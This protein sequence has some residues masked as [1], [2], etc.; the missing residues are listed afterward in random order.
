MD[1]TLGIDLGTNSIGMTLRNEDFFKWYGVYTFKKG[2]G[3]G[4]S[5]EFSLAAE[6]TKNRSSRRLYNARRYRKWATLE[7]LIKNDFCPLP[8]ED[9]EKWKH[10]EKGVGRKFPVHNEKFNQ[11][12]KL[13]FNFDGAPDYSSPYQLRR[14]LITERLD[15]TIQG[16]R[17]KIGRA[18]YH[19]AQRRGFKSSR[20]IG[21]NE[22]TAVYKGSKETGTIGRNEYEDLIE[23]NG[24]LGAA[25]AKLEDEGIRIR[26]RYTLRSDYY[27]EVEKILTFQEIFDE[28]MI[29]AILKA[30]FFQRPL[31]SQKG[32]IGKCTMEPNK[33]RCPISHPN[34]EEYRA[35]SFVNNIKYK[36]TEEDDF[37]PL[38][39]PLKE[40]LIKEKLFLK[41]N[42]VDFLQLRKFICKDERKNWILNYSKRMDKVSVSTCPVSTYLQAAF[43]ENWREIQIKSNRIRKDNGNKI[44]Y[45]IEDIWHILFSFEDEEYF[46]EF[47]IT[48]LELEENQISELLKLWK[49]FPVGYANL[50][51]KAINH[52]LPFL[53]KGIIYSEAVFLAKIPEMIGKQLFED[54]SEELILQFEKLIDTIKY[55]KSIINI[56]NSLI[57]TYKGQ[58]ID[59]R[60]ARK[61]FSY[62]L[63]EYDQKDVLRT[64]EDYYGKKTW[65]SLGETDKENLLND[66]AAEYQEFFKDTK[67]DYRKQPKLV[68]AFYNFLSENFSLNEKQ[69]KKL[70]HPSMID[71]YPSEEDQTLLKSP[72]TRA[73]KNPMAYKTLHKLR[74]VINHLIEKGLIDNETRIVLEVARELNDKN[75]RAAIEDYQRERERENLEYA[76]AIS[77]LINDPDFSG[78][79]NPNSPTDREKFRIWSEQTNVSEDDLKE[80]FRA[81]SSVKKYRLWKEQNAVCLYTGRF[82]SLTDLFNENVI[83]FEHT[84]P[85]S[86]SF[87]NSLANLTVCY[88]D[89]NRNVKKNQIPT[90]LPNY[91]ENSGGYQAIEPRLENWKKK[92][93]SLENQIET[94]VIKSKTA[95]DKETKDNAIR[96]RHYLKMHLDYWQNKLDRFTREDVPTGFRNS[97]LVDTQLISKYAY[98]YLKTVFNQ[99]DVIK[100]STTAEFRKIYGI[101]P[102]DAEKDRSNHYHH[103]IDAAV[104]TLLPSSAR[105]KDI[106][107]KKYRFEEKYKNKTYHEKPF[108]SFD[109]SMIEKIKKEILI[110]NMNDQDKVLAPVI[111]RVR[112]RGKI[113][114]LRDEDG[115]FVKDDNGKRIP[116]ITTGDAVRGQ[117][118]LDTFYGKIKIAAKDENGS[119]LR[120][121]SGDIVYLEENG[122]EVFKM[123]GRKPIEKVNFSSDNIIDK[124]LEDYLRK[125]LDSGVKQNELKDFQGNVVRHLRCEVK[126]GKGY[127]KPDNA[128]IVKEQTYKSK[129]EYKNFYYADSGDNYMF[130]LYENEYGRKIISI[131]VLEATKYTVDQNKDS[132]SE[133]FQTIEPISIGKGKHQELGKLKHIFMPGQKILFFFESKEE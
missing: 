48:S 70:Y 131:N 116:K 41:K 36:E 120:D 128:T 27:K 121:E 132:K 76:M 34:F 65:E 52:I 98:H 23:K 60:H 73:F 85:R 3:D 89:Y 109:Y 80:I 101:Q 45:N 106:L 110:N 68:E 64:L 93:E 6:R 12:I 86:L 54:N 25:F 55:Q 133:I 111:K 72:K 107:E 9:L 67:R 113:E 24:S 75:K 71:I 2:V 81:E 95:Q 58:E 42:N 30:I 49:N 94:Q 62:L 33:P 32:L 46:E 43:G 123:V 104:L 74:Q 69:L 7:V 57:A 115:Q 96:R 100:G 53:K 87:D 129:K 91:S 13:D 51:L 35:W 79:A 17:Y 102:S 108:E 59:D 18:L 22:K 88:A 26:N 90:Q 127:M 83:D 47:L 103:A 63:N 97:Q 21:A 29:H 39:L 66:V 130:G 77:E 126:S 50:S 44:I 5:G 37:Q 84:I 82:I 114:Y 38:P 78:N 19:I 10:Y 124:Q 105:R 40:N 112:S 20:K 15:L 122:K 16:N 11:W 125:Q 14:E 8:I 1:N 92:I 119:L 4:K 56:T 31:R 28:K 118:H 117:L 61:D 99:V